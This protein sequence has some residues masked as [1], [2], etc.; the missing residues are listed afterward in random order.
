[1]LWA[2]RPQTLVS[3]PTTD[4]GESEVAVF[5]SR[6]ARQYPRV[7]SSKWAMNDP[8]SETLTGSPIWRCGAGHHGPRVLGADL[9]AYNG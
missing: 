6:R 7:G 3:A 9:S 8:A 5:P 1:M 4:P 2:S